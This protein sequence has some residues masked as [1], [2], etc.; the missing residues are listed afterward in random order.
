MLNL[1]ILLAPRKKLLYIILTRN[2]EIIYIP[3]ISLRIRQSFIS[4]RHA[5]HAN[6]AR[7]S[8][9]TFDWRNKKRAHVAG[10]WSVFRNC[11]QT[12]IIRFARLPSACHRPANIFIISKVDTIYYTLA[13]S[14]TLT[15]NKFNFLISYRLFSH[16]Q[17]NQCR[18]KL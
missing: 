17:T 14:C 13:G 1:A 18:I 10:A 4:P 7:L 9:E 12:E 11:N 5:T 16:F 3:S 8:R 6:Q 15:S 2:P